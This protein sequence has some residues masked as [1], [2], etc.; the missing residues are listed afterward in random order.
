MKPHSGVVVG[1]CSARRHAPCRSTALQRDRHH[2]PARYAGDYAIVRRAP[3]PRPMMKLCRI[4]G[5]KLHV[6]EAT[7]L[8]R[9]ATGAAV[10]GVIVGGDIIEADAVVIA[11][12]PLGRFWGAVAAASR[13]IRIAKPEPGLQ[14][15]HG[16]SG[17]CGFWNA[18][19]RTASRFRLHYSPAATERRISPLSPT[20]ARFCSICR[21]GARSSRDRTPA[22]DRRMA[23]RPSVLSASSRG[24]L[25]PPGHGGRPAVDRQGSGCGWRLRRHRPQRLGFLTRRRPAKPWRN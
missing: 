11:M 24:N 20:S 3:S 9:S 12:G 15:G 1:E 4:L 2:L 13:R 17:R 6:G 25:L 5:A 22:G 7:A 10:T 19:T 8:V 18:R 14:H 21:G 23:P 16:C